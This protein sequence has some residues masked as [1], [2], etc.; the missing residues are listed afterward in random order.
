M[1]ENEKITKTTV[2]PEAD[3]TEE[4]SKAQLRTYEGDIL[5]G[6]LAAADFREDE[7]SLVPIEIARGGTVLFTFRIRPLSEEEYNRCKEKN[8]KYVRNKQL[9]IKFPEDTNATRYR[10]QLIYEAT[11]EEDRA[12]VWDNKEAWRAP[13]INVTNGIDMIDKVLR[14]GEKD[15]VLNK[16]DDISGYSST[17]EEVA[18]K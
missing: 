2:I 16:I 11:V 6:L 18:G 15:A 14:A 1:A 12:K 4:E 8:T 13:K 9:G 17:L 10:S 5:K 7:E 3:L